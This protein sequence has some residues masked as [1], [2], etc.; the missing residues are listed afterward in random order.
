M[1]YADDRPPI[2]SGNTVLLGCVHCR[3]V[4]CHAC[5]PAVLRQLVADVFSSLVGA[6]SLKPK[7]PRNDHALNRPF[8]RVQRVRLVLGWYTFHQF[9]ISAFAY[10][11]E[12]AKRLRLDGHDR[13]D[14]HHCKRIGY[15][16]FRFIT[17]ILLVANT[18][19]TDIVRIHA[20]L[21]N[22]PCRLGIAQYFHAPSV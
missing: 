19:C 16:M 12:A 5:F 7:S 9:S 13:V 2:S 10:I 22:D 8:Q 6:E 1:D 14:I 15:R 3:G 17:V 18:E 20:I 21:K 4:L 11:A